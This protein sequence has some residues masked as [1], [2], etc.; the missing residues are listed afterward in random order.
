M[1]IRLRLAA[2][3]ALGTAVLLATVGWAFATKLHSDLVL[4]LDSG[5]RPRADLLARAVVSNGDLSGLDVTVRSLGDSLSQ[6]YDP[7]A[8]VVAAS[9]EAGRAPL[10][11]A[12]HLNAARHRSVSLT[13]PVHAS[14]PD[15]AATE[16]ARV[17]AV[18]VVRGGSTWVVVVGSSL[19]TVENATQRVRHAFL[20]A[21]LPAVLLAG[22]AAGLVARGALRPVERM[23]RE[24]SD[25]SEHGLGAS[26]AVPATHDEIAALA[27]TMNTV[28]GR[29]KSALDRQRAF[30]A[31]A[32]HELRTPLSILRLELDLASA[33]GRS[34]EDLRAAVT[35]AAFET[36]RLARLAEDLLTLALDDDQGALPGRDSVN[37]AE[38]AA[39]SVAAFSAPAAQRGVTITCNADSAVSIAGDAARMRQAVDNLLAN[40]VQLA[41]NGS[42]VTVAVRRQGVVGTVEVTDDGPGFPAEF[43]P[44]AFERFRR[45]DSARARSEGGTGLG[46]AIVAGVARAHGGAAAVGNRPG[47][48]AWARIEVP[49]RP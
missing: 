45:A 36:D 44:H 30:V 48:G 26:I 6:V 11:D 37:L 41:P 49:C 40:A 15:S 13:V 20:L 29:L 39:E 46:L 33:P 38:V 24:V 12:A 31:D 22:L 42:E 16:M 2:L 47:G 27:A 17:I 8:T 23:R 21:G 34:N 18:P 3:F 19:E 43:V 28:L 1:P 4:S 32:G 10:L 35:A 5:L 9:V 25:I 14:S 7:S